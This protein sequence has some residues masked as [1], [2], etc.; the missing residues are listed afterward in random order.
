MTPYT[1]LAALIMWGA[2]LAGVGIWQHKEGAQGEIVKQQAKD[3]ESTN[4]RASD[5]LMQRKARDMGEANHLAALDRTTKQLGAA[6]AEIQNLSGRP[7]LGSNV[8]RVLNDIGSSGESVPTTTTVPEGATQAFAT[9]RDLANSIAICRSSY[10]AV[11][12]QINQI[13]DIEEKREK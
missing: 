1:Y 6:N 5:D 11:S 8:V 13:L 10:A 9:D 12:D 2:S 4:L 3:L 7:C